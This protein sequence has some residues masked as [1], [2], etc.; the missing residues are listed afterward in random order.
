MNI[1]FRFIFSARGKINSRHIADKT[2]T[3]AIGTIFANKVLTLVDA[4]VRVIHLSLTVF[5]RQHELL[6]TSKS[7]RNLCTD[8]VLGDIVIIIDVETHIFPHSVVLLVS[9]IGILI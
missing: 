5:A 8:A 4:K 3:L 9:I 6:S 1:L 7:L 2:F